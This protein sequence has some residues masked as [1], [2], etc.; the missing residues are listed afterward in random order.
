MEIDKEEIHQYLKSV[1]TNVGIFSVITEYKVVRA[2]LL[3]FNSNPPPIKLIPSI[4]IELEYLE[5][6]GSYKRK[7]AK[8]MM[9]NES[10]FLAWKRNNTLNSIGI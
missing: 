4:M 2:E 1:G 9:I 7:M 5:G 10:D 6:K 8:S 3:S